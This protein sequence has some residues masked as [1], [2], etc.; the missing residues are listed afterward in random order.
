MRQL[1]PILFLLLAG[2]ANMTPQEKRNV[3]IGIGV[4]LAVGAIVASQDQDPAREP[5][6][7]FIVVGPDGGSQITRCR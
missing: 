2:C 6:N 7:D 4:G 3:W 5:C 1:F